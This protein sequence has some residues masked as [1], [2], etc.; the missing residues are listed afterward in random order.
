MTLAVNPQPKVFR[1]A[2]TRA[3]ALLLLWLTAS[4]SSAQISATPNGSAAALAQS[5]VG[6]GVT[7]TNTTLVCPS[8]G[9]GF[10]TAS[11]SSL[12]IAN[13]VVL[14]TGYAT[15]IANPNDD[16]S[17][18]VDA[19]MPGDFNLGSITTNTTYDACVLEFDVTV[20]GDT[21]M[22]DYCFGSDEYNEFVN[23]P[24]NDVFGFFISGPGITG[25]QNI[26]RIPGTGLPVNINNVNCG[27]Y[28]QYYICNDPWDPFVGGC[29][30]QCPDFST[31][32]GPEYDGFTTVL[33]ARAIVQPCQ[34]YHL[35]LGVAD[36][37]DGIYDSGVFIKQGSL[38][39][40]TVDAF[41]TLR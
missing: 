24:Y 21:L 39:S 23:S 37:G 22:F 8:S 5:L 16:P 41:S 31:A 28:P 18:S 6:N 2:L 33:T 19:S 27:S 26:A 40:I 30:S 1:L 34:T 12:D 4:S 3:T 25:T 32:S 9:A 13:G 36:V 10:F 38:S 15:D 29:T 35:K 11:P 17:I 14:T 20:T 7:V